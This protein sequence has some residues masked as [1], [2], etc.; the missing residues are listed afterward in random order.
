MSVQQR[1]ERLLEEQMNETLSRSA[2][3]PGNTIEKK[4]KQENLKK[5]NAL[6]VVIYLG[7]PPKKKVYVCKHIDSPMVTSYYHSV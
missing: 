4:M 1:D 6:V 3:P 5:R 7:D 2:F